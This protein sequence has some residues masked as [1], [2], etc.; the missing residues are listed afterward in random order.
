MALVMHASSFSITYGESPSPAHDLNQARF[1]KSVL[2]VNHSTDGRALDAARK[3][4]VKSGSI[5][6]ADGS[7]VVRIGHTQVVC[8]L[9]LEVGKPIDLAPRA[10]RIGTIHTTPTFASSIMI[11]FIIVVIVTQQNI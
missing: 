4:T 11:A 9:K 5:S 3:T 6:S 2:C 1:D 10:G 8:G 7:S